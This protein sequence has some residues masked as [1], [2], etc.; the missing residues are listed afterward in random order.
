MMLRLLLGQ[1]ERQVILIVHEDGKV[2]TRARRA[3]QR[4]GYMVH[5]TADAAEVDDL[6]LGLRPDLVLLPDR[7]GA[8]SA[9]EILARWRTAGL[10]APSIHLRARWFRAR[11]LTD[12]VDAALRDAEI[13]R[14]AVGA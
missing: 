3:L 2:R 7:I 13:G 11:T 9:L 1:V 5:E 14:L 10:R 8:D 6:V 12:R 4:Q